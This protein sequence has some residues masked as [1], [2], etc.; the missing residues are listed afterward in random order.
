MT[1]TNSIK[2]LPRGSDTTKNGDEIEITPE[3]IEAGGRVLAYH[4]PA[5]DERDDTVVEIYRIMETV[6]LAGASQ[7]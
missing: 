3:M 6:R 5:N 7:R 4:D 2:H 1:H